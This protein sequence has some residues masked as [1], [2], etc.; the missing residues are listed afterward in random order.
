V[1]PN[2]KRSTSAGYCS[3][4]PTSGSRSTALAGYASDVVVGSV[5]S[6]L[7]Q[8]RYCGSTVGFGVDV[9]VDGIAYGA[10]VK[11]CACD[12]DAFTCVALDVTMR[13]AKRRRTWFG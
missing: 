11:I 8:A 1:G 7:S 6:Y 9:S 4:Q 13:F 10:S 12:P 5:G 3:S 2:Q